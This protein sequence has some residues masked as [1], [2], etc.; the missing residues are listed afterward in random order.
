MYQR[1]DDVACIGNVIGSVILN[2]IKVEKV[3]PIHKLNILS[4]RA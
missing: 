3:R 4:Y 1:L 2:F